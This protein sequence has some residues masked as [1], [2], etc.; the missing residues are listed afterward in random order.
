MTLLDHAI[1]YLRRGWRPVPVPKGM[2]KPVLDDWQKLRLTEGEL[3]AHFSNGC[4][5]GLILGE[6]SGWLVNV[7]KDC[8]EAIELGP[9][10]LP[11]TPAVSG[12]P[13]TPTSP[14]WYYSEVPKTRQFRD[15]VTQKMIVELRS[16]GGQTIV[17]PSIHPE[18][19]QYIVLTA[20]PARK[21][22]K[23]EKKA[24]ETTE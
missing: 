4:N 9:L 17:G 24:E 10:Y 21:S 19:E 6:P 7:D 14:D 5:I 1:E 3:P 8:P 16:T 13:S 23:A 11:P 15:P 22:K 12:R 2:K 20:K 18:G